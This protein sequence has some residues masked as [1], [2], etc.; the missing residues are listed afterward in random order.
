MGYIAFYVTIPLH[1]I[2]HQRK[3]DGAL[4]FTFALF[5]AGMDPKGSLPLSKHESE[6]HQTTK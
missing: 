6:S 4:A 1:D 5:P 3:K 2:K